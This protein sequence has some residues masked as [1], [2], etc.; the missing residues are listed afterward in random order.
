[1]IYNLEHL[2]QE[3]NQEVLGPLQDDEALLLYSIIRTMRIH[4]IIEIG[5]LHGYSARNFSN[6][7]L[8][9]KIYTVDI[10][11]V[12]K[13]ADNH[14]VIQKDCR[15]IVKSDVP[16][17][18][19]MIFFDA[20][21]YGAQLAFF[22]ILL[23]NNMIDDSVV[24]AFH[25]TNLHPYAVSPDSSYVIEDGWCHQ[26]VERMLVEYFKK[27]GYDAINFHTKL[28]EPT[29]KYRHGITIMRKYKKLTV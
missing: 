24:L 18:I 14:V 27:Q 22:N 13:V 19:D 25:D 26:P 20:H 10:N 28:D 2:T 6:A 12:I 9:G 5:G 11:P 4:N 7:L 21:V 1:M 29:I 3:S 23:K 8:D 16:D 15:N 17:K